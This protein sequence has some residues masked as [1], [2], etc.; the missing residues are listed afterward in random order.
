MRLAWRGCLRPCYNS[1]IPFLTPIRHHLMMANKKEF[2]VAVV[3]ET[4]LAVPITGNFET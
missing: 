4:A 1:E 3:I 2:P